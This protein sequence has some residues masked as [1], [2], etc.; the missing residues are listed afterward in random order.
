MEQSRD[1]LQAPLAL[2]QVSDPILSAR[3]SPK[4]SGNNKWI[5]LIRFQGQMNPIADLYAHNNQYYYYNSLQHGL[6]WKGLT[7]FE[8]LP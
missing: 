3:F 8:A 1:P 6:F 4:T 5:A 7:S 2:A